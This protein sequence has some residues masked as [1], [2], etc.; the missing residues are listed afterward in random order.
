VAELSETLARPAQNLA[1]IGLV[2]ARNAGYLRI[3]IIKETATRFEI[4][5]LP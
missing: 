3:G 4:D 1:G 2:L 5:Q